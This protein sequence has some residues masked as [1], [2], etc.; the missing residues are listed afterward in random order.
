MC[1]A[2]CSANFSASAVR[3]VELWPRMSHCRITTPGDQKITVLPLLGSVPK[4]CGPAGFSSSVIDNRRCR[5]T[6]G[7]LAAALPACMM[8]GNTRMLSGTVLFD[9]SAPPADVHN[10]PD[11]ASGY[12]ATRSR[13]ITVRACC[14]ERSK[15]REITQQRTTGPGSAD[16]GGGRC[17][18]RTPTS[19]SN[20]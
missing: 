6:V 7:Q 9:I 19:A 16:T 5:R 12:L 10:R 2:G 8:A 20:L 18:R 14:D 4:L 3:T 11:G 15:C 1:A 17:L 13:R